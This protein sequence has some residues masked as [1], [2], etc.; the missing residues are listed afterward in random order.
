ME[1]QNLEQDIAR[2]AQS[3]ASR[4]PARE[5]S[6][7][8]MALLLLLCFLTVVAHVAGSCSVQ[9]LLENATVL[10]GLEASVEALVQLTVLARDVDVSLAEANACSS[11]NERLTHFAAAVS[12]VQAACAAVREAWAPHLTREL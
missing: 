9:Q 7:C 10:A 2:C 8:L 3:L 1:V 6:A 12:T 5:N 11:A 4:L